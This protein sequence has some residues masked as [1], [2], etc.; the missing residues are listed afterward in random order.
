MRFISL[1]A[2][3]SHRPLFLYFTR[4]PS[5]RK[6]ETYILCFSGLIDRIDRTVGPTADPLR[7]PSPIDPNYTND[8]PYSTPPGQLIRGLHAD[9]TARPFQRQGHGSVPDHDGESTIPPLFSSTSRPRHRLTQATQPARSRARPSPA[10]LRQDVAPANVHQQ[11][12]RPTAFQQDPN[13]LCGLPAGVGEGLPIRVFSI[14][15][16]A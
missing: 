5:V 1:S 12:R 14:S 16:Q 10:L 8:P 7:T 15:R 2:V 9:S 3:A 13:R 6:S 4:Q 11:P